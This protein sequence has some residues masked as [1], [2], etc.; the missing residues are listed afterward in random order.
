M[1]R[2]LLLAALFA[3]AATTAFAANGL[4][5]PSLKMSPQHDG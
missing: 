1:I 4:V 2:P 3:S 5:E